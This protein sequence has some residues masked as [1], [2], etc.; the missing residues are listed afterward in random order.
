MVNFGNDISFSRPCFILFL[1]N[2]N[3]SDNESTTYHFE[4]IFQN[5]IGFNPEI[6]LR[7]I[8]GNAV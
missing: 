8:S 3:C 4:S 1:R 7:S 2:L 6:E 5:T